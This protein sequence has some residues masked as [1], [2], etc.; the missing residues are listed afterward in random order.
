MLNC[1]NFDNSIIFELQLHSHENVFLS[2]S[3]CHL[4]E[5]FFTSL[6]ELCEYVFF[7]VAH[8]NVVNIPSNVASG[9]FCVF[10][11][12]VIY[13][14]VASILAAYLRYIRLRDPDIQVQYS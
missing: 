12:W 5:F 7:E 10:V 1:L 2:A 6:D 8:E 13:F 4:L 11:C 3:H 14:Q 9:S